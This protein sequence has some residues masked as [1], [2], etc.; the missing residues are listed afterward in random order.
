V[1]A[2][3]VA[4]LGEFGAAQAN[5]DP[6]T[7]LVAGS[8]PGESG[9]AVFCHRFDGGM[10]FRNTP[11]QHFI[12]FA[13][14]IRV[15]LRMAGQ[16]V[17]YEPPAGS[18]IIHPAG[19]DWAADADESVDAL[20]VAIDPAWLA[21]AAA[22]GSERQA[23]LIE[24]VSSYDH[25]L[26]ALARTLAFESTDDYPNGPLF[27]NEIASRFID[28]LAARHMSA[29]PVRARGMLSSD[30]LRRIKEYVVAHLDEPI[31]VAALAGIAARSPFHFTRLFTPSRRPDAAPLCYTSAIAAG[32]RAGARRAIGPRRDRRLHRL[33]R[34]EPLVALGSA[35]AWGFSDAA[36]CL[37]YR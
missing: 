25:S 11:P 10:H 12:C 29:L 16:V 18:L 31:E 30:A 14:Q 24:R 8:A 7:T 27:W 15:E 23:Q 3:I 37:T 35:G 4:A 22:E 20:T 17:C 33:C 19:L 6:P 2:D 34:P 13:S 28:R 36:D 21:L 26:L 32:G 5:G 1:R 9:V